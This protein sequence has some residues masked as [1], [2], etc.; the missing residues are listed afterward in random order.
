MDPTT[1]LLGFS[2]AALLLTLTP[3]L[4]T[5]L[6]LRTA[7]VEGGRQ[8]MLAGGGIVAGVLA[9]GLIA[10]V[11][12]GAILAV[13]QTA[14]AVLQLAGAAYLLWLGAVMLH[15]AVGQRHHYLSTE[16]FAPGARPSRRWFLRG[17]LTNLLNPKVGVFYVSLLPQFLPEGVHV[18]AFSA[19][20]AGIHAAMGLLWFAALVLATRPLARWLQQPAV[21]RSL[22]ALTGATLM[23]FGLRLAL[24]RQP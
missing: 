15:R 11:G 19:L 1:A 9:W 23:L 10:A 16:A 4:D 13:S 20:L 8:A 5:A 12:L 7:A 18:V 24:A 17:L 3:G 14:Y 6:V 22:N 2:L 21:Q